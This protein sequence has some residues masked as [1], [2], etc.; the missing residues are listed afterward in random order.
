MFSNLRLKYKLLLIPFLALIAFFMVFLATQYFGTKNQKL[1]T[2]IE[3]GHVRALELSHELE[4]TLEEMQYSLQNA[5]AS[6]D[7]AE[8]NVSDSLRNIFLQQVAAGQS[9][10]VINQKN[11]Q[12]LGREF[13][14]YYILARKCSKAMIKG[15]LDERI[16]KKLEAM[17]EKYN[18]IKSYL[19]KNT[20]RNRENIVTAFSTTK[21]NYQKSVWITSSI[22]FVIVLIISLISII[23]LKS[24][25]RGIGQ[26]IRAARELAQGNV[27]VKLNIDG[28]DEFSKLARIFTTL[29]NRTKDLTNAAHAIGEGQYDVPVAIRSSKDI[30]GNALSVMKENL[31]RMSREA[32]QENWFKTGQAELSDH[33]R[34]ELEIHKLANNVVNFLARYLNVQAGALYLVDENKKLKYISGYGVKQ[35]SDFSYEFK[36]GEGLVGQVALEKKAILLTDVPDDYIKISSGLGERTPDTIYIAPFLYDGEVIGVIELGS[37]GYP[38]ELQ[39]QFLERVTEIISINFVN[40]RSHQKLER[41]LEDSQQKAEELQR[42]QEELRQVNEQLEEQ[43]RALKASESRLQ[44]QQ[45]ELQQTNEELEEQAKILQQQKKMLHKKNEDLKKAQKLVE[46]KARA[47]EQS[48]RYK[49]EFLAN[50]S[51]E[52]RTPL[53]SLLILSKLLADNKD[54][55]LT[56]N[57]V[58]FARTI[59]SAGSDLLRLINDILDLSKVEAGKLEL[60]IDRVNVNEIAT[61]LHHEFTS[62]AEQKGLT[63]TVKVAKNIPETLLSDQ[64]RIEQVLK[65]LISN[66]IKFTK[67]GG[68][69]VKIHLPDRRMKRKHGGLNKHGCIAFTVS[70]TGIGIPKQKQQLIFEAFRQADGTTQR[71]FGGTGLGLSISQELTRLLGGE[72]YLQSK[73]GKGSTFT[74]Y[75]PESIEESNC[76]S[77]KTKTSSLP[78]TIDEGSR[79]NSQKEPNPTGG[80]RTENEIQP[81]PIELSDDRDSLAAED[82]SVL[83]IE[84]RPEMARRLQKVAKENGFKHL[85]AGSGTAGLALVEKYEP[86][87]IIINLDLPDNQGFSTLQK[88]KENPRSRRIPVHVISDAD[89]GEK[90]TRMGALGILRDPIDLAETNSAFQKIKS[91]VS[92][93]VKKLLLVEDNQIERESIVQLIG[94]GDVKTTAVSSGQQ[95]LK[96]LKTES[97]DC[98]ILDLGLTDISGF[99]LLEKLKKEEQVETPPI[100]V[101]TGRALSRKEEIMLQHLT[102]RV[103]IKGENS[104]RRLLDETSL[105]LHRVEADLPREKQ[106][107]IRMAH[108]KET[109][110]QG[111]KVLLVDDD[112]RNAFAL[113]HFLEQKG[114][115]I[116]IAK[117]G[118]EGIEKLRNNPDINLVLMDI[119]MPEMDGFQAMGEIRKQETFKKLPII[120]LTAK[121]MKG[122]KEKCIRAGASDYVS[123][124]VDMNHLLTLLRVWLYQ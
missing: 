25:T 77:P 71:K 122:D 58:K 34:R 73:P 62:V 53:N 30:L 108:N 16:I 7:E 105:F 85:Y 93:D 52:L 22:I 89:S 118:K 59:H 26:V 110:L 24:I 91:F 46:E 32:A 90:A 65:N 97:F 60:L 54:G 81:P 38:S 117:N 87:A 48:N 37:F 74:L 36:I 57:Q 75:L 64:Q 113:S 9:I 114:M 100:I 120:A 63:F 103:I 43:T 124:P 86:T 76:S 66:A 3:T 18:N 70:D 10:S 8:L 99:E 104:A 15:E 39:L 45:E 96:L 56:E 116:L 49:S 21:Q 111:K 61:H 33:M 102:E 69:T 95:A 94:N 79:K 50:M 72:I 20:R 115:Q 107:I 28:R 5:V 41:A 83:I 17:Q 88:L 106:K 4:S 29:V 101:H 14:S 82:R 92:R 80:D 78:E 67:K 98:M 44:A 35:N 42:Q 55:N 47:L 109:I 123:K 6:T 2:E 51:H 19:S 13:I 31:I 84:P 11:L 40:A 112:M 1:L 12:K 119:M 121:A 27:E 23:V 68:V